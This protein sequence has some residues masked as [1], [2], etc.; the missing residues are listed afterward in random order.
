MLRS[1]F[2]LVLCV[3]TLGLGLWVA[4]MAS[5]NRARGADLNKRHFQAETKQ[6][7]NQLQRARNQ[8]AEFRLIE[9]LGSEVTPIIES[10]SH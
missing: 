5:T 6:R 7:Q 1:L 9:G 3:A 10:F 8:E 4:L 2:A